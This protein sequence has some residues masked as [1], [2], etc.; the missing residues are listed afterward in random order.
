MNQESEPNSK[1]VLIGKVHSPQGIRGELF[2]SI[3]SGEAAWYEQWDTLYL[4]TDSEESPTLEMKIKRSREHQKQGRWGF[5]VTT[6]EVKDRSRAEDMKGYKVY[7][8][9]SFLISEEG[10]ELYLREV[11]GFRVVDKTRGDVGEVIG[12]SGNS[13]QDILVIEGEQGHFEVPFVEPILIETDKDK[14]LLQMDIPL[15]LVAGET[16]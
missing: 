5:A 16:L 2:V 4:S 15:G 6:E 7:I 1:F 12:F 14:R 3:F 8:P 10:E 9:E 13:M 11:L